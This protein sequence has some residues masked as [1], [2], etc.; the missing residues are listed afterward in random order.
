MGWFFLGV[1]RFSHRLRAD[2]VSLPLEQVPLLLLLNEA[3]AR[4]ARDELKSQGCREARV[5]A[6]GAGR[7]AR[8]GGCVGDL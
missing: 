5:R 8:G 4:S 2:Q 1:I 6:G 3:L 7:R